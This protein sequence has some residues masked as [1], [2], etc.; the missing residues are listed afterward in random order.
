M[1]EPKAYEPEKLTVGVTW[2]WKELVRNQPRQWLSAAICF[3]RTSSQSY[4][5]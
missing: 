1:A 3:P 4:K 2:N 5:N